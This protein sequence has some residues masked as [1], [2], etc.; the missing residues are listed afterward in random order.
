[1]KKLAILTAVLALAFTTGIGQNRAKQR[2]DDFVPGDITLFEDS[3]IGE[4]LGEFPSRWDL[5]NGVVEVMQMDG[6][7]VIGFVRSGSEI[8]PL[9]NSNTYLPE[10]FTLELSQKRAAKV[11]DA[12]VREGIANHRLRSE[13]LGESQPV[14]SNDTEEGK[15]ANRRV[16]FV[17]LNN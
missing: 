3:L 17:L 2:A 4:Q 16:A 5:K 14:A 10:H 9:M 8:I 12:L 11:K 1:M 13:G 6:P 15:A 7:G